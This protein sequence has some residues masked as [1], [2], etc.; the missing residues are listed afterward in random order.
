MSASLSIKYDYLCGRENPDE[1][2]EAISLYIKTY[3]E[4]A[5]LMAD[6][7]GCEVDYKFSLE[8]VTEGSIFSKVVALRDTISAHIEE[9]LY[10]SGN[11]LFEDLSEVNETKSEEQVNDL[12]LSLEDRLWENV[13]DQISY[14]HVDRRRLVYILSSFS[15]AN[16][17]ALEGE[18]VMFA[19]ANDAVN[20]Q[21][22]NI[23][24]RF[25]GDPK[26]MF[27]GKIENKTSFLRMYASVTVYEGN[28]N[29]KFNCITLK[30]KFHARIVDKEWLERYQAGIIKP[31]G[32]NDVLY[33]EVQ[34]DI[35][36]PPNGKEEVK[37]AKVL[38]V[39]EIKRNDGY[40][41]EL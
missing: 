4:L 16:K 32:P 23:E 37:N 1:V 35:Y 26:R 9:A 12:A 13:P 14:P 25:T 10:V 6:A 11:E 41:H 3:R 15:K 28:A 24:W 22:V 36:T 8:S 39:I 34:Y 40:Q 7:I 18:E 33:A 27:L 38:R 2:F 20:A 31:I 29:W 21:P 19:S 30:R 5:Q 17:K